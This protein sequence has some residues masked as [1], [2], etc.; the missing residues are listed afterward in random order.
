MKSIIKERKFPGFS[1][2]FDGI[3]DVL[4]QH[5]LIFFSE[6]YGCHVGLHQVTIVFQRVFPALVKVSELSQSLAFLDLEGSTH[7]VEDLG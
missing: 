7:L 6:L 2:I 1:T 5:P 3:E 4:L